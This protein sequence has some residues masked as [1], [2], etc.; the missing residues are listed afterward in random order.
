ML[1]GTIII[2]CLFMLLI[3][4]SLGRRIG[5]KEGYE[6]ALSYVPLAL[7]IEYFQ[8]NQCPICFKQQ[9][10]KGGKG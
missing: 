8:R 2:I 5:K 1:Y 9:H 6:K 3:G 10:H 4:Y 7:K